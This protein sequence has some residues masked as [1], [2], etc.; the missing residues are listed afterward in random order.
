MLKKLPLTLCL[1]IGVIFSGT[2]AR[3]A[4]QQRIVQSGIAE[5]ANS[6]IIAQQIS[7]SAATLTLEDLPPGFQQLPPAFVSQLASQ[8][9]AFSQQLA[10]GNLNPENFFA[11]VN[12]ATFQV[13]LGFTG[14]VPE[15][16]EQINFDANL[17]KLDD[18]QAQERVVDLLTE[19]L[20]EFGG[21]QIENYAPMPEMKTLADASAGMTM[22]VNM[23]GQPLRL[24]MASFRRNDVVAF[25]GVLYPNEQESVVQVGELV[26]KL[27]ERIVKAR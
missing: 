8:F 16:S 14:D 15:Q 22:L 10:P 17:Q 20:K 24:D 6:Q 4:I 27:D 19:K 23:Q 11:F 25:T 9:E 5:P 12:P 3:A 13:V 18:P 26:N 1:L 21:I 7:S 2:I